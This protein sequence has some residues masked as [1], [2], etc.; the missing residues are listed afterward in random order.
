MKIKLDENIP[1]AV[2]ILLRGRGINLDTVLEESLGGRTNPEVLAAAILEERLLI[3]LDRGF[4]DVRAYPPGSHPGII[5]LRPT[6]QRVH[7]VVNMVETLIDS[8]R[9]ES[10]AGCVTVIPRNML[11][12][13]RP[14]SSSPCKRQRPTALHVSR[15]VLNST[16]PRNGRSI[17]CDRAAR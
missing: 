2:A 6:D 11:R 9:I 5:M 15:G 12:V 3:T 8:H 13:R 10:L 4:G 14:V 1:I 17:A 7:T 16:E